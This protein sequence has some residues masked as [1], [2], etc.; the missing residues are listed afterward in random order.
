MNSG[1]LRL[2]SIFFAFFTIAFFVLGFMHIYDRYA[3]PIFAY[4]QPTK[5]KIPSKLSALPVQLHIPALK[6]TLPISPEYISSDGWDVPKQTV[7]YIKNP[8]LLGKPG[9]N[10]L[11]GHNWTPLLGNLYKVQLGD[12][13][14]LLYHDGTKKSF[15]IKEK[16]IVEAQDIH[17]LHSGDVAIFTCAGFLDSKRL[18]VIGVEE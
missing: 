17:S 18:V 3:E 8:E 7:A 9:G 16:S 14:E 13:F 6:L 11:V 5:H 2:L 10:I 15:N 12:T 1:L 4:S